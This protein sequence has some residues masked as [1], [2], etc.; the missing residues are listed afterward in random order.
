MGDRG[1]YCYVGVN[2]WVT[3]SSSSTEDDD[4][5]KTDYDFSI[6]DGQFTPLPLITR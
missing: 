4:N 2:I 5:N 1:Y 6:G 3:T